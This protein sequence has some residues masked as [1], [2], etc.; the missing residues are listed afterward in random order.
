MVLGAMEYMG[1]VGPE[2]LDMAALEAA[3]G[4]GQE[5][6]PQQITQAVT[7]VIAAKKD[8]LIAERYRLN[9]GARLRFPW[10]TV[11]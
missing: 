9:G 3:G 11:F 4:V 5:T 1:K 6:S 7:E 8:Q 2:P 10:R